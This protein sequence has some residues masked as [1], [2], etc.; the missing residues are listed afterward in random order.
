MRKIKNY[1][2]YTNENQNSLI[3]IA[4]S[5]EQLH[6]ISKEHKE[7]VWFEYDVLEKKEHL[8]TLLNERLFS[9]DVSFAKKTKKKK[10]PKKEK[11]ELILNSEMGDLK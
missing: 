7:G 1:L 11:E 3:A 2:L 6:E 8:D 4:H 9:S 5:E 10:K